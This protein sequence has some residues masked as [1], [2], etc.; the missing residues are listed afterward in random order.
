[1]TYIWVNY[2]AISFSINILTRDYFS[3]F[4]RQT[5]PNI[6]IASYDAVCL[7]LFTSCLIG[8]R[9]GKDNRILYIRRDSYRDPDIIT[10]RFMWGRHLKANATV[11]H[12]HKRNKAMEMTM[13]VTAFSEKNNYCSR[14]G[15]D[16]EQ[17]WKCVR[18]SKYIAVKLLTSTWHTTEI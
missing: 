1:M 11:N 16:R 4:N 5:Q 18:A 17:E 15:G 9:G 12:L 7:A 6:P 13:K 2:S 3:Y 10:P 8:L 14:N